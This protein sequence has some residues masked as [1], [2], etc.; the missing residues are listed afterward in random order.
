MLAA[1]R[2][3]VSNTLVV[4]WPSGF[5]S[6]DQIP[7]GVIRETGA[8]TQ[9]VNRCAEAVSQIKYAWC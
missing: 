4:I 5:V 8:V 9:G 3:V 2:L 6:P 7:G 1:R